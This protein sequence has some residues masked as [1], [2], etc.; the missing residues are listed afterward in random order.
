MAYWC[1]N[2]DGDAGPMGDQPR[3]Y[4]LHE[5]LR[6]HSW[7]MHYQ[8]AHHGNTYQGNSDQLA[9]TTKNW[10]AAAKIQV[11]DWIVAYLKS[12]RVFGVGEVV[13]R[14]SRDRHDGKPVNHDTIERTTKKRTH[15]F[16]EGIVEYAD[17]GALYEDFT[18]PWNLSLTN[19][20]T[21]EREVWPYPQRI[22]VKEW[23]FVVPNGIQVE[24]PWR[25]IPPYLIQLSVFEIPSE[26][27][28]SIR[29]ALKDVSTAS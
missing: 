18:S 6:E 26:F 15:Q 3:E 22:D 16:F 13:S 19:D 10:R 21:G 29:D 2:F 14:R 11:G 23:E 27:F 28:E 24:G 12:K 9:A 20:H 8:Y 25:K 1:V 7:L 4:V 5:G 17:S